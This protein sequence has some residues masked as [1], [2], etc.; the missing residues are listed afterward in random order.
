MAKKGK[1]GGGRRFVR[2]AIGRFATA[3]GQALGR[4]AKEAMKSAEE[5]L[6]NVA[7][8]A[9]RDG[10]A[11]ANERYQRAKRNWQEEKGDPSGVGTDSYEEA[12]AEYQA[13]IRAR[14]K[15]KLKQ[16]AAD[17]GK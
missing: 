7:K 6:T 3:G 8:Q 15:A 17:K 16:D 4:V 12:K 11:A 5:D 9:A 14:A 10:V 13:A 1:S 2:D